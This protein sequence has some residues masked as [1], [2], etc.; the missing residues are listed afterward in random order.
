MSIIGY[1]VF[2]LS[3]FYG[4]LIWQFPYN[5]VKE[6][7]VQGFAGVS[8]LHLTIG[9]VGPGFPDQLALENIRVHSSSLSFRVPDMVLH[10]DLLSLLGGARDFTVTGRNDPPIL[11]GKFHQRGDQ[12]HIKIRLQNLPILTSSTQ[13]LSFRINLSGEVMFQWVGENWEKGKGQG[14]VLLQRGEIHG[15]SQSD[16]PPFFAL[17]N[18]IRTDLQFQ[19]GI[20][21]VKRLEFSG[22]DL[23][24]S[25]KGS[26]PLSGKE[27]GGF[28]NL[29]FMGPQPGALPQPGLNP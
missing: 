17:L 23:K 14:W 5:Q 25:W 20:L 29:P 18:R 3:L 16:L 10:P 28:P 13:D 19:E 27:N 2:G 12:N 11:M 9:K 1:L 6:E 24:G 4:F 26:F 15:T 21:Y 7:M 8:P 22:K